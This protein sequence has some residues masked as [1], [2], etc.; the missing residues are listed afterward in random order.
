MPLVR[1]MDYLCKGKMLT[2]REVNK[3]VHN[4]LEK[5]FVRMDIFWDFFISAHETWD[6]HVA[7]I[8]LFSVDE[9]STE[10]RDS[11]DE[12]NKLKDQ[13]TANKARLYIKIPEVHVW[14]NVLKQPYK[15]LTSR[16]VN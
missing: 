16:L 4:I 13:L 1:W 2:N 15:T 10:L 8:F 11:L 7:F 3:L 5:R 9:K 6:R 14:S 12:V